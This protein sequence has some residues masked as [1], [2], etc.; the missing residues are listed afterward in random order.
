M[1]ARRFDIRISR[2]SRLGW[3]RTVATAFAALF[4]IVGIWSAVLNVLTP[5]GEDF[6]SFWAAGRLVLHGHPSLAYN[7]NVHGYMENVIAQIGG[8]MPFPYP[9]PFLAL[10]TPF[11]LLSFPAGLILWVVLTAAFFA[12]VS[13]RVV[14]LRYAFSNAAALIDLIIGQSGFLF[15]GIFILGLTLISSAPFVAGVV[16]GT[17]IMKPQLALLLPVAMLA[18][19]EWRVIAGAI[20]SAAALLL[21]GLILFGPKSY[22]GFWNILPVYVDMLRDN[23]EPWNELASPFALARFAGIPQNPALVIHA[24]VALGAAAAT[25]RAWWLKLDE[26]VPILAAASMLMSPY[27]YTYD[28]LLIVVP[29]GWLVK[30]RCH[31][32]FI[33]FVWFC[34]FI[35]IITYFSPWIGPNFNS[36]AAVACLCILHVK[37][38]ARDR[39]RDKVTRSIA[40]EN[41]HDG[42]APAV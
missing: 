17:L 16:L 13:S 10:V 24:V 26:R 23:R 19:R 1:A 5:S 36:I 3:T 42:L 7:I 28:A 39:R 35:P 8:S 32:L 22:L 21:F 20:L 12:I 37:G 40:A 31:P 11:A 27:F 4:V 25:A 33:A 18:G 34:C 38:S 14:P 29:I 30:Q 9:P 6:L 2:A 41:S 15:A